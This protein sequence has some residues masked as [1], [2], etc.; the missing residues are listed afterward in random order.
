MTSNV[1]ILDDA[2]QE[3]QV[4]AKL[5]REEGFEVFEA[6]NVS[7]FQNIIANTEI[8]YAIIDVDLLP[9]TQ[10]ERIKSEQKIRN[11]PTYVPEE[12]QGFEVASW[13][14]SQFPRTLIGFISG[15]KKDLHD[16]LKGLGKAD[17]YHLKEEGNQ[18]LTV[19]QIIARIRR[20]KNRAWTNASFGSVNYDVVNR[21][22]E[23]EFGASTILTSAEAD[24]LKILIEKCPD[25]A[26]KKELFEKVFD[27]PHEPNSRTIDTIV[28]KIRR[29]IK[30]IGGS[31]SAIQTKSRLGYVIEG[32]VNRY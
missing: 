13:V 3:M 27:K 15:Q 28:F 20:F 14:K 9:M 2:L 11:I 19:S 16:Q 17:D 26:S 24:T 18:E 31:E 25:H 21:V 6:D 5:L 1:A 10:I 30:N 22:L 7:D 32:P 23:S 4:H 29:K 8:D 12:R